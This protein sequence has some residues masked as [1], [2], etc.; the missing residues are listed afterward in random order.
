M[1]EAGER[2]LRAGEEGGECRSADGQ[3]CG[4]LGREG[5]EAGAEED[6]IDLVVGVAEID[7]PGEEAILR[8]VELGEGFVALRRAADAQQALA[9]WNAVKDAEVVAL[10]QAYGARVTGVGAMVDRS[11]AALCLGVPVRSLV[12]YPLQAAPPDACPQ[13]AAG[14]PLSAQRREIEVGGDGE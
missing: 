12:A 6:E 10:A 1:V 4:G 13:C 14:V 9:S 2:A 5:A 7:R 11:Q 8:G 3:R